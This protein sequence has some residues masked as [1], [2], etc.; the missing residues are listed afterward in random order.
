MSYN[1]TCSNS[2]FLTCVA[3]LTLLFA[4][5]G[6]RL[7]NRISEPEPSPPGING[8]YR[9]SP[10][11]FTVCSITDDSNCIA[12]TVDQ[13]PSMVKEIFTD[14][15]I[16]QVASSEQAAIFNSSGTAG[17]PVYY[18]SSYN[19]GLSGSTSPQTLW[20]NSACKSHLY[21]AENGKLN[22]FT[23]FQQFG[24]F[25]ISGRL[26]LVFEAEEAFE[27]TGCEAELDAMHL[28]Y[29]N[30]ANCPGGQ[31]DYDYVHE[32]FDIFVNNG[33]ITSVNIKNLTSIYYAASFR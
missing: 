16:F 19:L 10:Q 11:E 8:F 3:G 13:I 28:C 9:T 12:T 2:K 26:D 14:P 1:Q 4:A 29:D 6:C 27:G 31:A 30:L 15:V 7:G 22:R 25:A 24:L 20:Y 18:D 33:A 23:S 5:S 17:F 32:K 21:I